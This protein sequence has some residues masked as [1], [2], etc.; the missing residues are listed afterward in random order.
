V[1]GV[2]QVCG[3][4]TILEQFTDFQIEVNSRKYQSLLDKEREKA[5][6]QEGLIKAIDLIDVIIEIIRGSKNV[7]DAKEALMGRPDNVTFKTKKAE[8]IARTLTFTEAD[9]AATFLFTLTEDAHRLRRLRTS[10]GTSERL[11]ASGTFTRTPETR[12]RSE[13]SALAILSV[14]AGFSR[15]PHR[16]HAH[17]SPHGL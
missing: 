16:K 7:K 8:K 14:T 15:R 10:S 4:K 13:L 1:D 12:T 2:P 9:T 3:L 11:R 6:I 17:G 5:E